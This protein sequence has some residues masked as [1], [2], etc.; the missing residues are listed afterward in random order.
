M[1]NLDVANRFFD[2]LLAG[3]RDALEALFAPGATFWQ[4]FNPGSTQARHE[5]LPRFAALAGLIPEVHFENVRRTGTPAGFVEQHTLAGTTP[6]G[7]E[8]AAHGCFLGTVENGQITRIEEWL[9]SA[10]L[11]P[12]RR[13]RRAS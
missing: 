12:L 2:A 11:E 6:A 13:A 5:F 9:D 1:T 10:Q 3:D 4:N 8:F 7:E